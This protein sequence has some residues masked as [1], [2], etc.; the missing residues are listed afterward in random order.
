[1]VEVGIAGTVRGGFTPTV[2]I[3]DDDEL[4]TRRWSREFLGNTSLGVIV[5]NSLKEAADLVE[6]GGVNIDAVVADMYFG[7]GTS[8]DARDLGDGLA[9]LA[10]TRKQ[11]LD[12][13]LFVISANVDMIDY[14]KRSEALDLHVVEFFDKFSFGATGE[15]I[16]MR[17]QRAILEQKVGGPDGLAVLAGSASVEESASTEALNRALS[18]LQLAVRTYLQQLPDKSFKILKPIEVICVAQTDGTVKAYAPALGL[19]TVA[20]GESVREALELL[21]EAIGV[22]AQSLMKASPNGL[23]EYAALMVTKLRNFVGEA[24]DADGGGPE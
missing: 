4:V 21:G 18:R 10:W 11:G 20:Q 16:W 5:A 13:P 8:D 23:S 7:Y 2:L 22:E 14:R 3:V 9:F 12:V 17:I 15:S 1:M 6:E 24:D 19:L